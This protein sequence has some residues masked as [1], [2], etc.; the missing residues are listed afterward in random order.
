MLRRIDRLADARHRAS[1]PSAAASRCCTPSSTQII[2]RIRATACIAGLIT[3]GYLLTPSASSGSTRR[4]RYLQIS[5]DNVMPDEV[6]K[7]SLKVL[8][9]KLQL[10]AEHARLPRQHQ[11]R[12]RRRHQEPAGRAHHRQAR[13]RARLH[14]ARSASSTTGTG[15]SSRSA[16]D[17]RAVYDADAAASAKRS[18]RASTTSRQ[19]HRGRPTTW[20]C[21]AGARYLYI[22]EDGLVHYCSQQRGYPG[23]PL[24][25]YTRGGHSPRIPHA[26]AAR[27]T[28]PSRC[29]HRASEI[30]NKY[31]QPLL[32]LRSFARASVL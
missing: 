15:S 31:R 3:N 24:E 6:S 25:Q 26:K 20:H 21:R 11:L 5:I 10:L 9:K 32:K 8:D 4:P 30:D 17:E 19:P 29:V 2:R 1:S 28:A 16:S 18:T 7:K 13:R 14:D 27:P 22:C 23:I 12:R